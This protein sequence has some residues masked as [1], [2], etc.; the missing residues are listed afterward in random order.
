ML[1]HLLPV[2]FLSRKRKPR[3]LPDDVVDHIIGFLPWTMSHHVVLFNAALVCRSWYLLA[4]PYIFQSL[5]IRDTARIEEIRSKM[6]EI[7]AL[8]Q[9]IREI[10]IHRPRNFEELLGSEHL[11]T[12]IQSLPR[13][14]SLVFKLVRCNSD[15]RSKFEI[16]DR[17]V[18]VLPQCQSI[19]SISYVHCTVAAALVT[20]FLLLPPNLKHVS[21]VSLE[22]RRIVKDSSGYIAY[23]R[24]VSLTLKGPHSTSIPL[25]A[26][27]TVEQLQSLTIEDVSIRLSRIYLNFLFRAIGPSLQ[28]LEFLHSDNDLRSRDDVQALRKSCIHSVWYIYPPTLHR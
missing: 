20:P 6:K 25:H 9:W 5:S 18:H 27:E 10:R 16:L 26:T 17:F 2:T 24:L 7:P 22:T 11:W 4:R 13:L 14:N 19:Q 12:F 1:A 23:P 28:S 21:L 15:P 3:H 8:C